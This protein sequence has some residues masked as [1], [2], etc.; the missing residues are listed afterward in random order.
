MQQLLKGVALSMTCLAISACQPKIEYRFKPLPLPA[1]RI[2]CVAIDPANRPKLT[3]IYSIDWGTI[4]NV[5]AA[6]AE[7]SKL[8]GS[9]YER[10]GIVGK[11]ILD[12][13]GTQFLCASDAEWLRDYV[14]NVEK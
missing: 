1:E 4:L 6:K 5:E 3:P 9:V 11:Y 7:V 10:E 8:L 14:K 2:D 12:V 13:E